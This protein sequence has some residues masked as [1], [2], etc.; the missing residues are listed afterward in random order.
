MVYGVL[1]DTEKLLTPREILALRK[2]FKGVDGILHAGPVGDLRV[3]EQLE[4]IAPTK[5][6][7]GNSESAMIRSEFA[8]MAPIGTVGL[9]AK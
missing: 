9:L 5:A 3:L 6:V 1:A 2:V 7:C 4:K 8:T